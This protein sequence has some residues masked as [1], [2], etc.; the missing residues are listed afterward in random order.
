[1]LTN[2]DQAFLIDNAPSMAEHWIY[3]RELVSVLVAF[4]YGQDDDGIDLYFTDSSQLVGTFHEPKQF[5][6]E[7]TKHRPNDGS[8][9]KF[10]DT[11]SPT[12]NRQSDFVPLQPIPR[13]GTASTSSSSDLSANIYEV[14]KEILRDWSNRFLKKEDKKEKKKL[15]LIVL[16]DG[17]W[18]GVLRKSIVAR[19]I[20]NAVENAQSRGSLR[21]QLGQRGLSIQF[22]R[23]GNDPD[24]VAELDYMDNDLAGEDGEPLP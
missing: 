9:P 22:V 10:S 16:T 19:E 20:T 4:L 11:Q 8:Q 17:I 13:A 6:E 2:L 7:M 14:L 15:T 3:A 1:M 12:I 24:A 21:K 5:V 18:A 23:F